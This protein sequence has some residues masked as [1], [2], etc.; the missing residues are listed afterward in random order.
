MAGTVTSAGAHKSR[1]IHAHP[2]LA[3]ADLPCRFEAL[4]HPELAEWLEHD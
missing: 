2:L 3:D 4:P 1:A